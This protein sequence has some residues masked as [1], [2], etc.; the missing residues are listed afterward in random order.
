MTDIRKLHGFLRSEF[1]LEA[2]SGFKLA[3][4]VPD[5]R[6]KHF[7]DYYAS[8]STHGQDQLASA[9][10]L[11]GAI[12]ISGEEGAR[13]MPTVNE[14][15]AWKAWLHES[16]AGLSRDPHY[17]HSVKDLQGCLAQ[18]R[19]DIART[20][21]VSV[22]QDLV[23]YANTIRGAKTPELRKRVSSAMKGLFE[24]APVTIGNNSGN[25][26]GM[27]GGSRVGI[28]LDFG[29]RYHQLGY[30]IEVDST[31]PP[32]RLTRAGFEMA[33]GI[34]LGNWDFIDDRNVDDS[35]VLLCEFVRYIAELPQRMPAGCLQA[36]QPR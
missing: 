28:G 33:L 10:T 21:P 15:P 29:S 5:M 35:I 7:L 17:Y 1:E 2:S 9:A 26:D 11:R 6:V 32:G 22:P 3:R 12:W 8:L 20:R 19:A 14:M 18:A 31:D 36:A 16:V 13:D 34:G 30:R 4:R 27:L 23:D 25:C 24:P